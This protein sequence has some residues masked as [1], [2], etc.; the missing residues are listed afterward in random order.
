M[1]LQL[2]MSASVS[3]FSLAFFLRNPRH[4]NSSETHVNFGSLRDEVVNH[5]LL[6]HVSSIVQR[7]AATRELSVHV[8]ILRSQTKKAGFVVSQP[9]RVSQQK[10]LPFPF[11]APNAPLRQQAPSQ[12]RDHRS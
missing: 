11:K 6:A 10:Q 5:V 1:C 2:F 4:I 7:A 12:R 3:L 9:A 8:D